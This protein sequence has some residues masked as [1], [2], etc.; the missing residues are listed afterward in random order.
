[1]LTAGAG[2][3]FR[4][5]VGTRSAC[6]PTAWFSADRDRLGRTL[7]R[8]RPAHGDA[9]DLGE[10]QEAVVQP[11]ATVLP[12]LRIGEA[13]VAAD[14]LKAGI[15]RRLASADA[16]EECLKGVVQPQ[17][18]ILQDLGI[19]LGELRAGLLQIWQFRLLLVVGG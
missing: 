11:S 16:A 1:R 12:H 9:P 19:D 14:T 5:H 6:I 8:A 17:E 13:G 10:D 7:K 18:H 2:Q 3:D 4:W 15:A